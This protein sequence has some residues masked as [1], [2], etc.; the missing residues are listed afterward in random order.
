MSKVLCNF[1]LDSELPQSK[2]FCFAKWLSMAVIIDNLEMKWAILG[3]L[4]AVALQLSSAAYQ[5]SILKNKDQKDFDMNDEAIGAIEFPDGQNETNFDALDCT[6]S[7]S[8]SQSYD[9][10]IPSV[11]ILIFWIF[12]GFYNNGYSKVLYQFFSLVFAGN[13]F[14]NT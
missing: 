13:P 1:E 8:V 12:L 14:K 5:C 4:L 2:Q 3:L 9:H 11:E 6:C 10:K 7:D